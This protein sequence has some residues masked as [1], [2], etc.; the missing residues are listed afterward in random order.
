MFLPPSPPSSGGSVSGHS[1]RWRRTQ[2]LRPFAAPSSHRLCPTVAL[3]PFLLPAF[4]PSGG[5]CFPAVCCRLATRYYVGSDS[6]RF[7]SLDPVVA[8][9]FGDVVPA[10]RRSPRHRRWSGCNAG[11]HLRESFDGSSTARSPRVTR[12]SSRP[13]HPAQ[14]TRAGTEDV[15]Y[16]R[17]LGASAPI[18]AWPPRVGLIHG[19][20]SVTA[21]SFAFQPSGLPLL[22]LPCL[23]L[24]RPR[25]VGGDQTLTGWSCVLPGARSRSA[26]SANFNWSLL[27]SL[28]ILPS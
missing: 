4:L 26:S 5:F 24:P 6:S 1:A 27:K 25:T 9:A 28:D 14:P 21:Q 20:T 8:D 19:F 11:H 22:G 17:P 2:T 12:M 18:A 7:W 16:L 23:R 3:W 10:G 15:H 13:R